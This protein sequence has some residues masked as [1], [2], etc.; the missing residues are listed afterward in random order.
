MWTEVL[1]GLSHD[2]N[3]MAAVVAIYFF[4]RLTSP[5]KVLAVFHIIF[6][7]H[8]LW[9]KYLA[10]TYQNN[11]PSLHS[12]T[13]IQFITYW[14]FFFLVLTKKAHRIFMLILLLFYMVISVISTMYWDNIFEPPGALNMVVMCV[15]LVLSL[16]YFFQ[17]Y[18]ESIIL[19]VEKE[20]NFL[21][22]SSILL[23]N[24]SYVFLEYFKQYMNK[25]NLSEVLN[26]FEFSTRSLVYFIYIFAII[27]AFVIS[28]TR[29]TNSSNLIINESR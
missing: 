22:S 1:F 3:W 14:L 25:N 11:M 4:R 6:P 12:E 8:N 7:F 17:I 27:S 16:L 24:M 29:K 13:H 19:Y 21:V 2:T 18:S 23:I 28:G 20:P 9:G 15:M 10:L 26:E 5:L